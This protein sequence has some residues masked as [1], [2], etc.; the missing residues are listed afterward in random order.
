MPQLVGCR[1]I[2]CLLIT[3]W[4]V[5]QPTSQLTKGSWKTFATSQILSL[6]RQGKI[7]QI[8]EQNCVFALHIWYLIHFHTFL[9]GA[10]FCI[11]IRCCRFFSKFGFLTTLH[12][13]LPKQPFCKDNIL[14]RLVNIYFILCSS[15]NNVASGSFGSYRDCSPKRKVAF[16]KTHKCA[17]TSI[18]NILMR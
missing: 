6:V 12:W 2:L 8:F 9:F 4:Q 11:R 3:T 7:S 14:F 13:S 18:Q 17:S 16:L 15:N 5:S 10:H 1:T